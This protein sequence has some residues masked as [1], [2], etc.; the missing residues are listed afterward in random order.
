MDDNQKSSVIASMFGPGSQKIPQNPPQEPNK[1]IDKEELAR[2]IAKKFMERANQKRQRF[3]KKERK[4]AQRTIYKIVIE[5]LD[6]IEK[7]TKDS[8]TAPPSQLRLPSTT[9]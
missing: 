4:R 3:N 7:E 1:L 2:R 8:D 6:E 9:P 5:A